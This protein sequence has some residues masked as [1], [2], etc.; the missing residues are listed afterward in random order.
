MSKL[1]E[2]FNKELHIVN[3]GIE[4]FYH[5][6][7]GQ[8][9][10][11]VHV[12]WKPVAGG[13]KEAAGNLRKLKNPAIYEKI[14]EA[15]KEALRR[16]L[17]AQP[18]L[19]GLGIA[20]EVIPGM[21]KDTILHA[22]PPITWDRMCGPMKGAV[23][24]GLILEGQAKDLKEAEA[25]AASGKIK[26]DPCH[27]HNAVGPMAGVVTYSMPVWIIENKAF[28][29]RAY[30]TLNEGLGKVL[31]FGA[32]DQEV[33]TRLHWMRDVLYPVL[34]AGMEIKGEIDLKT[35]IAQVLQMGDEAHN[36]NK[37][38][39]SLMFRELTPA[40][41]ATDLPN[42]QKI[43]ALNFINNND[44]TFLNISMPACK[45]TMD[46]IF[47]IPYCSIVA[48]M[49]RNGTDFG[50]RIAGL[51]K[52]QWF[53]ATAEYVQGLYFP[54]FTEQDAARDLGDSCIT[55][56]TGIGGFCMAAAPAIVQFVGG[57]VSDALNYSKTMYEITVGEG[58]AYK[59]PALDFRGSPTGIDMLKVIETGIRPIINTGIAHKDYGV[60]QVGAGIVNPP[61]DCFI[62]ALKAFADKYAD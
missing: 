57:Q 47:D 5:D 22:G 62:Q 59:I 41:L 32:C 45:C 19:V 7:K 29:N 37:A 21:T 40:I 34:K 48:T 33:F 2:L 4:S 27:M 42:Q 23:M 16:I 43:D 61:E 25:L 8:K 26:F 35:M 46:P 31:R 3:F 17:A 50:I 54:G 52:D 1:N 39:T 12:D 38:G 58:Q 51:G 28:G 20:G 60:G 36:R 10:P 15:N 49:N 30:C 56:T 14:Q 6:L 24:G 18:T 13:N 55:E 9:E 11:A 53:A 44:H